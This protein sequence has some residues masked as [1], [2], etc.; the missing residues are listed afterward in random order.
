MFLQKVPPSC[1]GSTNNGVLVREHKLTFSL[2]GL[3]PSML[4]RSML[5]EI[6]LCCI[7]NRIQCHG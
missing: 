3:Y 4:V 5:N 6:M 7:F 2:R 1:W